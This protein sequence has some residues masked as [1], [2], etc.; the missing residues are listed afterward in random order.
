MLN[1]LAQMDLSICQAVLM[2]SSTVIPS[3]TE[4]EQYRLRNVRLA[5]KGF[6]PHYQASGVYQPLALKDITPR[7]SSWLSLPWLGTDLPVFPLFADSLMPHASLFAKALN[8]VVEETAL[9]NLQAEF[10]SLVNRVISADKITIKSRKDMDSVVKK[11]CGYLSLGLEI[12]H[13]QSEPCLPSHGMAII[14]TYS[15]ETGVSNGLGCR[16]SA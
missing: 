8:G 1:S 7:A 12:I 13:G 14:M 3:E 10:A 16:Y 9:M 15:L 11:T 4:E 6:L 2:E 5:E